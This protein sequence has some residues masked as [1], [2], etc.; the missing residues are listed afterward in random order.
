MTWRGRLIVLSGGVEWSTHHR[1]IFAAIDIQQAPSFLSQFHAGAMSQV[2]W[3]NIAFNVSTT[4]VTSSGSATLQLTVAEGQ[5]FQ[6]SLL[7][8][9]QPVP[10]VGTNGTSLPV[11]IEV[12]GSGWAGTVTVSPIDLYMISIYQSSAGGLNIRGVSNYTLSAAS[13]VAP[14]ALGCPG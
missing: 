2:S 4:P 9:N 5:S 10:I 3:Q 14:L 6:S 8:Q 11:A 7:G 12:S 13:L 1:S